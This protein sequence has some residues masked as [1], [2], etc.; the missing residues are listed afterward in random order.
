MMPQ[1]HDFSQ[2][3]WDELNVVESLRTD[4]FV[5]GAD[6][7]TYYRPV[8]PALPGM[9][10]GGSRKSRWEEAQERAQAD[11]TI[12]R[13]LFQPG[14]GVV[15]H[16]ASVVH[17]RTGR[18]VPRLD[19]LV[20]SGDALLLDGSTPPSPHHPLPRPTIPCPAPVAS[21]PPL[22]S[23]ALPRDHPL[24]GYHAVHKRTGVAIRRTDAHYAE[25]LE[26][27]LG[28]VT[29]V[30]G[31]RIEV[32]DGSFRSV[33]QDDRTLMTF[34]NVAAVAPSARDD[35]LE[36]TPVI[37]LP[38]FEEDEEGLVRIVGSAEHPDPL[39]RSTAHPSFSF[40]NVQLQAPAAPPA[41]GWRLQVVEMP[42]LFL[43]TP[44]DGVWPKGL[45]ALTEDL[46][47][48]IVLVRETRVPALLVRNLKVHARAR[49]HAHAHVHV[50]TCT[51]ACAC[52][53]A[54]IQL[55]SCTCC[56]CATSRCTPC[57]ARRASTR[58]TPTI[59]T[60]GGPPPPRR[61][62]TCTRRTRRATSFDSSRRRLRSTSS[63]V[64]TWP[65]ATRCASS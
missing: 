13:R 33:R 49:A 45:R 42:H 37:T 23:P 5:R 46:P 22:S 63:R 51:C 34:Y 10:A 20:Q 52:A 58:S 1:V 24:A 60:R 19:A 28:T 7:V 47:H 30:V 64:G 38:P 32:F 57:R 4:H 25:G 16:G 8:E 62:T 48:S 12:G 26:V 35:D 41:N 29:G 55:T 3:E 18:R 54:C 40:R 11:A 6:G 65:A 53:C 44:P 43:Y 9:R 27:E 50:H 36:T 2:A 17:K 39:G 61:S 14:D 21:Y 15:L 59:T 31:E 56:S